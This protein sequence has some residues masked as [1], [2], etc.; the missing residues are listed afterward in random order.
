MGSFFVAIQLTQTLCPIPLL[1]SLESEFICDWMSTP[2]DLS[3]KDLLKSKSLTNQPATN[4]SSNLP[5]KSL[6]DLPKCSC[7]FGPM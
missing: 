5:D 3:M 4:V 2:L 7:Y 1:W 6:R